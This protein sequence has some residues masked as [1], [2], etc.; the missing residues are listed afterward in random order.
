MK[1]LTIMISSR[2]CFVF[3]FFYYIPIVI[4]VAIITNITVPVMKRLTIMISSRIATVIDIAIA[5]IIINESIVKKNRRYN[6][7]K[8][9]GSHSR[10]PYHYI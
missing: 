5:T 6:S 1:R 2:I 10:C 7:W 4:I 3:I 8:H 9:H